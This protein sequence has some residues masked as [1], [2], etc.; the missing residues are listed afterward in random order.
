LY[1]PRDILVLLN[2]AY[3]NA[4]RDNREQIIESDIEKSATAISQYRLEDLCKE[5]DQVLP[6]LRLF[7]SAFRGQPALR[8]MGQVVDNLEEV[9][10]MNDYSE[11]ASGDLMLFKNGDEMFSVLYSVGFIGLRDVLTGSY[12]FCHDGTMRALVSIESTRETLVHPCYWKAL[13]VSIEEEPST[14]VLQVNDEYAVIPDKESIELRLQRLGRLPEELGGIPVGHAGSREFE[15]WV[16]RTV[17]VLFS[18]AL[19]H[20]ELKPNPSAA[21]SQRDIVG[22]N[23][24]QTTFWRRIYED[25]KS[26][27]IIF[28]CKNYE[29]L[30]PD[31]FRQVLDYSTGD[32]GNFILVARRGSNNVTNNLLTENEKDRTKSMFFEH[33]R[34]I[35]IAPTSLLSLCIRKRRSPKKYD[36]TE[37]I[38]SNHLDWIA[39]S[40]LSLTHTP[41]YKIKRK[42]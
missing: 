5:H 35:M 19:S 23:T 36:Y 7:V 4:R 8:L 26:R 30:T 41:R 31:D 39:R 18:G 12:A 33:K 15:T 9:A 32:Y 17:R 42:K 27:Q 2:E 11:S 28:E 14:V 21:L 6:G 29:E 24:T 1:R 38:M 22:T 16:L 20:I 10:A 25:Y 34:I 40:V 13:D 37:Y 3:L